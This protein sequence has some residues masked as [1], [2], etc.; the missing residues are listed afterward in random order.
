L[1]DLVP[2]IDGADDDLD[3]LDVV[4]LKVLPNPIEEL[5]PNQRVDKVRGPHLYCRGARDH[6]FDGISGVGD[7]AHSD[8]R[9]FDRL[10][11]SY[12]IR[13]AIGRIAGP[14]SPPMPFEIFG[15]RVSTSITIARNVLTSDTASAPAS[16]ASRANDAT[17]V[18]F[19]VSLGISGKRVTF[20]TALTTSWVPC[21][22][23]PN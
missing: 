2:S 20:L 1:N 3:V 22:L 18:T 4:T 10:R 16:S 14:L 8:D 17:S 21:K 5:A 13:T 19:G 7:P 15:R 23:H 9:D 11:H 12:T 6:E